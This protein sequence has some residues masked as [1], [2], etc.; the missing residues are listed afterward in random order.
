TDIFLSLPSPKNAS[1]RPSGEKNGAAAPCTVANGVAVNWSRRRT[2]KRGA[3]SAS[4]CATN[5]S[6]VP[7]GDTTAFA[8]PADVALPLIMMREASAPSS[9]LTRIETR[10]GVRVH[11]AHNRSITTAVRIAID[12]TIQCS[13]CLEL[14]AGRVN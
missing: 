10:S 3:P 8:P 1:H 12:V 2:Y 14:G 11:G 7:S 9:A 4:D 5:A 6:W 13:T